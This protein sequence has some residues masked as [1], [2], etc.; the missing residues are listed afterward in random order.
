MHPTSALVVRKLIAAIEGIGGA[1]GAL[2]F[3]RHAVTVTRAH[4]D[5][6]LVAPLHLAAF[7]L[8]VVGALLLWFDKRPGATLTLL[9]LALQVPSVRT[10]TLGYSFS[11]GLGF[12]VLAGA[13]GMSHL[14]FLGCELHVTLHEAAMRAVVGINVVA[15]A[16]GVLL[17][18]SGRT[19]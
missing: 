15:L 8:C 7:G 12:R 19:R 6:W 17:W 14:A 3:L 9:A 1:L 13:H 18:T 16:L 2:L 11:V 5:V 10:A 4:P